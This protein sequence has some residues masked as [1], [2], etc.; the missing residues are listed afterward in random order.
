[1]SDPDQA[2]RS[3]SLRAAGELNRRDLIAALQE[4]VADD[5]ESCRFWAA[6]SSTLLRAPQGLASLTQWLGHAGRFGLAA[7]QLSLR[8]MRPEEA[9][10]WIRM[11]ARDDELRRMAILGVGAI[12]DP[13]S[14]PWLIEKMHSSELAQLAGEAFSTLT[15][16]DLARESLDEPQRA[17]N[18]QNGDSANDLIGV[19]YE[20][21]LPVPNAA[22]VETWWNNHGAEFD[23]SLR[24]LMG[25]PLSAQTARQVLISGKQ[26]QRAAAA[27]ELAL[28]EE[29]ET[30]FEIRG[31]TTAQQG[32]LAA[33]RGS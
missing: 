18:V 23:L 6:W 20:S 27:V 12:G 26:R 2:L 19:N 4:H 32:Q 28:H 33:V 17:D 8:A 29:H 25:R 24:Y 31:R 21:Q 11:M 1:M 22:L 3:R 14:I 5:D 10:D 9:R 13:V 7:L 30:L 16:V 15:G